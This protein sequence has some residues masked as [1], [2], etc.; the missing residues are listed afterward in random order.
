GLTT[1]ALTGA[2][3]GV[4]GCSDSSGNGGAS[5][6]AMLEAIK[7]AVEPTI[8]GD[9]AA[10]AIRNPSEDLGALTF[11]DIDGKMI[12]MADTG[13]KIRLV[14]LWATWCAPCREE[15]PYLE[16]LQAER[17]GSDFEVVAISV[18]GGEPRKPLVFYEDIGLE[19]LPFYHDPTIG[20]FTELKKLGLAFGLPVTLLIDPQNRVIA[21]MNGPAQWASRDAFAMVDAAIAAANTGS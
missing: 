2:A 16:T 10:M 9:V 14:N 19:T 1:V 12:S 4:Y 13:Q 8:Q 17:G 6:D 15:M 3:L 7:A 11:N 21:N 20:V 18:D 5:S